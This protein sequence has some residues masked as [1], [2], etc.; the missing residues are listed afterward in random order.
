MTGRNAHSAAGVKVLIASITAVGSPTAT[1]QL[2]DRLLASINCAE[3][4]SLHFGHAAFDGERTQ[5]LFKRSK[6]RAIWRQ[7]KAFEPDV[8]YV[9]P[10]LRPGIFN[11]FVGCLVVFAAKRL[12]IHIMD[13]EVMD[14]A[15]GGLFKR[16]AFSL[17]LR[18][19]IRRADYV[20]TISPRMSAEYSARYGRASVPIANA[21]ELQLSATGAAM[22][23]SKEPRI[24][25]FGSLDERMN[26]NTVRQVA[27]AV[28]R[29]RAKGL[30]ASL[31]IYTRDLYLSWGAKH[32][33]FDGVR[34]HGLVPLAEYVLTLKRYDL[35]LIAYN[36]DAQSIDYCRYSIANKLADYIEAGRGIL[37]I[38]PPEIESVGLCIEHEIGHSLSGKE[39]LIERDL[40][41]FLTRV[42]TDGI[43]SR[44]NAAAYSNAMQV[45]DSR[46]VWNE[47]FGVAS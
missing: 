3:A 39:A 30:V 14:K 25:Y 26:R 31:D 33:D 44:A 21:P 20:F 22:I 7:I 27:M 12:V 47:A 40:E 23:R 2:M 19:L 16:G 29:L 18:W 45:A 34:L 32:L 43:D 9:R 46:V 1:G 42:V 35:L 28:A 17:Y 10:T 5:V 4:L 41:A 6:I 36:F 37:T 13:D 15:R 11:A 38:G 8:M 24:G